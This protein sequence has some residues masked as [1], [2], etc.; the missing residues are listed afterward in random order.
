M[1]GRIYVGYQLTL[2][3]TKYTGLRPFGFREEYLFMFSYYK[4]IIW[5]IMTPPRRGEFGPGAWLAGFIKWIAKHCYT[6]NIKAL[7]L[8][9]F[10]VFLL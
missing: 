8:M 10:Y 2:L 1:I 6:Q 5:Q 7:G 9:L 3:H 4:P